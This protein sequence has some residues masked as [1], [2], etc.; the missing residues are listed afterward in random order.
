MAGPTLAGSYSS[1]FYLTPS[2]VTNP[3]T[4]AAS[5]TF[6][7]VYA[8]AL[9]SDTLTAWTIVNYGQ[10]EPGHYSN[11]VGISLRAGGTITNQFGGAING[12]ADAIFITGGVGVVTNA[13]G[14]V[15]L[16]PV[17]IT[18]AG[19]AF[20]NAGVDS[21]RVDLQAGGTAT[22][23]L[24]GTI[25]GG[26]ISP[27]LEVDSSTAVVLNQ[28][29][30]FETASGIGIAVNMTSGGL[31]TNSG[32]ILAVN[33]GLDM[34]AGPSASSGPG[35]VINSGIILGTSS[36][37]AILV[38]GGTI[39][40]QNSGTISGGFEGVIIKGAAGTV[41]NLGHILATSTGPSGIG[42]KIQAGGS[43]FNEA[44]GTITG[45]EAG[46]YF[47]GQTGSITN[48]G[49]I[50]A[51]HGTGIG[52]QFGGLATNQSHGLISGGT[53]G[54]YS[55]GGP[56]SVTNAGTIA[57]SNGIGVL[58]VDG[59]SVSN[60][61]L[62]TVTSPGSYILPAGTIIGTRMG[63][64]IGQSG[65]VVNA[66]LI[67]ATNTNVQSYG[68]QLGGGAGSV[69][70]QAGGIILAYAR[71]VQSNGPT[72]IINAG[73]I[74]A[75][76]SNGIAVLFGGSA[77]NRLIINPGAVFVGSVVGSGYFPGP[78]VL[79]LASGSSQ[80]TIGGLGSQYTGF[81]DMTIDAG[82]SWQLT[83]V[84][85]ISIPETLTNAGTLKL[86]AASFT[87]TGGLVNNGLINIDPSTLTVAD[88]SG[89]GTIELGADSTL[90][91]SGSV[92]A[93][94]T[95]IFTGTNAV[96]NILQ[97]SNFLGTVQGQG[98][99]DQVN[100]SCFAAGTGLSTP[101]GTVAVEDLHEGD[102]V[103][104]M[105][106]NGSVRIIWRGERHIDCIRHPKP[107]QV[108]PVRIRRDAFG[109]AQPDHDLYLSPDHAVYINGVLIPVRYLING[110]TIEQ[111]PVDSVRYFHIELPA[112]DIVLADGLPVETYLDTGDRTNFITSPAPRLHPNFASVPTDGIARIWE[113]L[114]C[115]QLVVTGAALAA[116]RAHLDARAA[117]LCR[118]A[119]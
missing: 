95:I 73:T 63:V 24:G 32:R 97:S 2:T 5:A 44:A 12:D 119:A 50:G 104:T 53:E 98:S 28:G 18:Q 20:Y 114:G 81:T 33:T 23:V 27:A 118:A 85:T 111:V 7:A 110:Q 56:A 51:S 47:V 31:L 83:G 82:A 46:A 59:G 103:R 105:L 45:Y 70:N 9:F 67:K 71:G 80:G 112:H 86:L 96:L 26:S 34:G 66:G 88:L 106:G 116:A 62:T 15:I 77:L 22:N 8:A 21:G 38:S 109:P 58:L 6:N 49:S 3:I 91:L 76:G 52:F 30:I 57:A 39:T 11:T 36:Y 4:L 13:V 19:A 108:W 79:E 99:S 40:N 72:T 54:I 93:G 75:T 29:L 17:V 43:V 37:G 117:G 113:T 115:A 84:N 74:E 87:D 61:G 42:V 64:E 48:N 60:G 100:V 1:P 16:S 55:F 89:S 35:T 78:N 68:V 41:D 90:T 10:V 69:I 65:T 92:S 25:S 14:G 101:D 102:L 107:K 94:E